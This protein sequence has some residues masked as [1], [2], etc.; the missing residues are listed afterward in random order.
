LRR[1]TAETRKGVPYLIEFVVS[2]FGGGA[3]STWY[4]KVKPAAAET[5][6]RD[7]EP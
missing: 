4:Q 2:R 1:G 3:E 7:E 6:T 5:P